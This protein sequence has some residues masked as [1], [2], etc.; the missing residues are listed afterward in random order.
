MYVE[1]DEYCSIWVT[2]LCFIMKCRSP[3]TKGWE[4]LQSKSMLHWV[5]NLDQVMMTVKPHDHTAS[6]NEQLEF[7]REKKS[8]TTPSSQVSIL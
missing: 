2:E 4:P 8:L 6:L 1:I 5:L 7:S 3:I